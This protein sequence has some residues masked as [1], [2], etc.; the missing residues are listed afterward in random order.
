MIVMIC[1][2]GSTSLKFK[3]YDMPAEK[4]LASGGVE[5]VG[6]SD[7]AIYKYANE[8]KGVQIREEKQPVPDYQTG[9]RR[10]LADITSEER[11]V[12]ASVGEIERVG[13]KT[14]LSRGYYGVH[15]LTEPVLQGMRDMYAAAPAH[16]G[17]YL[18]A[19]EALREV[20]PETMFIGAFET[21]FHRT[22]PLERCIYGVPYE[23]A[24]KYG[25]RRMGY[26]GASHSYVASVLENREGKKYR[27]VSCHLGGSGS[28]CAIENGESRDSSF[29][30]TL[31]T[32][33]IHNNRVGAMDADIVYYL[34]AQGLTDEE[35]QRGMTKEG[36]LKGISGV[37]NDLRYVLEAAEQGNERAKLAVDV[38][39]TGIV[40]YIAA[41]AAEMRGL[42]CIAFTGGIGE[43]SDIIRKMVCE[44]LSYM[45]IRL[46]KRR[47]TQ[48]TG[49]RRI[50]KKDSPIR[51]YVIA[52]NEE[53]GVARKTYGYEKEIESNQ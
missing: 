7:D 14:V 53:L 42:D 22:I 18:A 16:N 27:A 8:A 5:R 1:N 38:Y 21:D 37:S 19:V 23:W 17:P 41:F 15:E 45:G 25:V 36:G 12:I 4:V 43:N 33:L 31:Q 11:G 30:L 47:N 2:A 51:V 49:D 48:K 9:I 24:E 39:V 28:I 3:L 6:S 50:T 20:L 46:S 52:A 40:R 29:G 13:F 10:F 34:R 26:H 32:G 44:R 35:I